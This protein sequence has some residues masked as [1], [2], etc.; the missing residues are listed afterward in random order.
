MRVLPQELLLNIRMVNV[1]LWLDILAILWHISI[2]YDRAFLYILL[3]FHCRHMVHNNGWLRVV[4]PPLH[5]CLYG[6]VCLPRATSPHYN[7]L[8]IWFPIV[9]IGRMIINLI[10]LGYEN[11]L[12]TF[13]ILFP[14]WV[15]IKAINEWRQWLVHTFWFRNSP[16]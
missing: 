11:S 8:I 7:F 5:V 16:I 13:I 2:A 9:L 15:D 14:S 4:R 10:Y 3:S 1:I 12:L 6:S